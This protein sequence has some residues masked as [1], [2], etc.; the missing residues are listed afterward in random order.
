VG[1]LVRRRP[2]SAEQNDR[3]GGTHDLAEL[4]S[5]I[6]GD[7]AV[8]ES[9]QTR[10][11]EAFRLRRQG[12]ELAR[13]STDEPAAPGT[14][15]ECL[16]FTSERCVIRA[17][18]ER[19]MAKPDEAIDLHGEVEGAAPSAVLVETPTDSTWGRVRG[20]GFE[21][22]GLARVSTRICLLVRDATQAWLV[23][24]EWITL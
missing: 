15:V 24:T 1:H 14:P 20:Q 11:K 5:A 8:P 7:E 23:E 10:L 12:T 6:G 16:T 19:C 22:R 2:G 13:L 18:A 21:A 4:C 9:L 17:T 3:S